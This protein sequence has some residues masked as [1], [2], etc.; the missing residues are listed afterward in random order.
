M[1][2]SGEGR[3]AAVPREVLRAAS[4]WMAHMNS[5]EATAAERQDLERWRSADELHELAWQRAVRLNAQLGRL[6]PLVSLQVLGRARRQAGRR[7]ALQSLAVFAVAAPVVYTLWRGISYGQDTWRVSHS[8]AT[9]EHRKVVLPDGT[10]LELNTATDIDVSFDSESKGL[11][12][13]KLHSGELQI[14]TAQ[15]SARRPFEVQTRHGRIRALGTRF[16]VRQTPA[17]STTLVAVQQSAVEVRPTNSNDPPFRI[18]AGL[19][20]RFDAAGAHEIVP[21]H[22][23]Q[24]A[25]VRGMLF[26]SNQRLA[27]FAAELGRYR[28]GVVRCAPEVAELRIS[29]A[30]R[31]DSTDEILAALPDTLPVR[32]AYRTRWWVEI[33]PLVQ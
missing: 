17:D 3:G 28:R 23:Q 15:D 27:D 5:G 18:E 13:V 21:E 11:R 33:R 29:G 1:T 26:A 8:T 24:D 25:W 7:S 14:E 2:G 20:T 19:Q 16:L 31:L 12:L 9:G 4:R 32:M 10:T 30:F 22:P 6:P